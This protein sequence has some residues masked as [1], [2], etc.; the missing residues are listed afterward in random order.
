MKS[1]LMHA[2]ELDADN[3]DLAPT[4]AIEFE[5]WDDTETTADIEL[6]LVQMH[7]RNA[8]QAD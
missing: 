7:A 1:H 8:W 4:N 3:D 2:D 5:E 6:L